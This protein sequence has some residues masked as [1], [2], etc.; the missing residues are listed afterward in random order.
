VDGVIALDQQMLVELLGATGPI[1]LEGVS[2]PIDSSNVIAYMRAAKTPTAEDLASPG[3]SYKAFINKITHALVTKIFTGEFQWEQLATVLLNVLNEHH[4]LLQ[5]DSPSMT[6]L[7]AR[8][9]W[10]GAVRPATGDFLMV[11]DTNIGFNKTNA[12]V[13]SSLV[14]DV[15]LTRLAAPIGS[16]A[17]V[18]K[19]NANGV[20]VCKQWDKIRL[21]G[22]DKYPITDCYWNYLRIYT[23]KGAQLLEAVPQYIPAGWMIRNQSVPAQ[24]DTLQDE[25]IDGV[26]VFGSLQVVPIGESLSASFRFALPAGVIKSGSGS[27]QSIYHLK[28]QKQPGTLAVPITIRV[29]FPNGASI[30]SIPKGAV[31]QGQNVFFETNLRTDIEFEIVFDAP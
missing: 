30:R 1:E 8:R 22:E 27:R 15:D 12:M 28:V 20:L 19:N 9:H 13:E 18:H 7:L 2:Y 25:E 14:Y 16:L 4:L 26:Q 11:V 6:S 23:A 21:A 24:V 17:V 29:H 31:V 10:D 3:W 5:L